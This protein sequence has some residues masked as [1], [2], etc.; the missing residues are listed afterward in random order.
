MRS[1][2]GIA[3][4]VWLLA[5]CSSGLGLTWN[6]AQECTRGGGWWRLNLGVCEIQGEGKR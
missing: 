6:E 5:G 2:I 3:V 4:V 1:V